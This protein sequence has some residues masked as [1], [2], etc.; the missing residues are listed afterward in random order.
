MSQNIINLEIKDYVIRYTEMNPKQPTQIIRFGEHFIPEGVVDGGIIVDSELFIKVLHTCVKKW[1]LK[2]KRVRLTMPDSLVIVRKQSIPASVEKEDI[3]RYIYF[4]LGDTIHLPFQKPIFETVLL[5]QGEDQHE[6]SIISTCES[7]VNPIL[8]CLEKVKTKV[9]AVDISPLNYY[10]IY[11]HKGKIAEE[12]HVLMIQYHSQ[13]VVFCAF[14]KHTPIFL[15][16]FQLTS[17]EGERNS[18]GPTMTREDFNREEVLMEYEEIRIEIERVERFYQYSMNDGSKAF[19]KTIVVGDHP[20]LSEII[21][22]M[23]ERSETD[24][25]A[26]TDDEIR[27]PKGLQVERKYHNVYGLA[28]KDGS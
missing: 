26:F 20:Y 1:S 14:E 10:R 9:V 17:S 8:K 13:N 3:N 7:L 15:Q 23:K 5:K 27:G 24:L 12:D 2:R 4:Q 25:M 22:R 18:F 28:M 11:Y 21:E 16:Q 19:T 6:V